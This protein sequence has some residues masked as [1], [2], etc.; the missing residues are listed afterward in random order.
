MAELVGCRAGRR[1]SCIFSDV[2]NPG[3]IFVNIG[4]DADISSHEVSDLDPL[5]L[6]FA[7]DSSDGHFLPE[8]MQRERERERW[9]DLLTGALQSPTGKSPD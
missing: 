1:V 2:L 4:V 5:E 8:I 3:Y 7:D 6:F 9:S